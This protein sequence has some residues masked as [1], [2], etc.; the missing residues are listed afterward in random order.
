MP[1]IETT[2]KLFYSLMGRPY[3]DAELEEIFPRAKAE[4]D[5]HDKEG[6]VIKI[7]LND[8]N[9]PDLWSPMG[10]ARLLKNYENPSIHHYDF[11]SSKNFTA[12]NEG[13]EMIIGPDASK[14]RPFG[15][16]FVA[17][18]KTV[19]EDI[20]L[21]L[22]Q[23]QEKLC[24]N[25]GRKRKSIAMG[26][27]RNNLIKYPIH[28]DGKDP[29]KEHFVP[30]HMDED[31]TLREILE[32][33]PKGQE[34]GH[35]IKDSPV[36]PFL[37]DDNGD[38]LSMPPIINSA[39]L[40][41]V[42]IGDD[43][44]YVDLSGTVLKDV[45]LCASIMACDM[46]DLGFEIKPIKIIYP[47]ETELGKEFTVPYYFQ[48]PAS[49]SIEQIHKTLGEEMSIE[50]AK[51]AL[52]RMGV[53]SVSK[54]NMIYITPP[55]YRNDFLHPVDI[56]EDVMI[57][58]GLGNF[59][60]VIPKDFTVG[61]LSPA[62]ELSRK[63]KDIMVGLGFQEMMYNY[64][65]SKKEYIENMHIKG[66]NVIIIANPM[67]ENFEAV[68]PSVL[69]SL[70]E[71]ESVSGNATYPHNIFEIGKV[72]YL[73]PEDNSGTTTR[74]SLGF[75]SADNSVG[76]NEANSFVNTLMYFLKKDY[77][78]RVPQDE[79]RFIP[80]RCAEIVVDS[81]VV[82]IFGEVHPAVLESW[83]CGMPTIAGE[84]DMDCLL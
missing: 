18:G 68:R 28:F 81:K 13:R 61:R 58:Y 22:I 16:G 9:R 30:L 37:Y 11:F 73:C 84:I 69:P 77:T 19:D 34:F 67:T 6:K 42:E 49:C 2:E 48:E 83:G 41:A 76:F 64:L 66:D 29:D 17:C 63:A 10:V 75:L 7:E 62:E 20:L 59:E 50:D 4:L 45:V 12:D 32:K 47:Y 57:G 70:L 5:E 26:I 80:G 35:I 43:N 24:W 72:A 38:V 53:Y 15:C 27:Y 14:V 21:T 65:G 55:E 82:G 33:H 25:F 39:R 31:L 46:A 3:S 8:T 71:S 52:M 74:N 54:D 51:D 79:P 36:Y 78:L 56:V 1:K 23:N 40:G 44:L 60:P